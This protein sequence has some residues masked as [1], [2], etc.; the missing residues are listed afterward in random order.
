MKI[1]IQSAGHTF[2]ESLIVGLKHNDSPGAY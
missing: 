2:I 1:N